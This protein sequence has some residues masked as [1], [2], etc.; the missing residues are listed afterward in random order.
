MFL[1]FCTDF[2]KEETDR[3]WLGILDHFIAIN[4]LT[5]ENIKNDKILNESGPEL[6]KNMI[7]VLQSNDVLST[8]VWTSTWEKIDNL[9]PELKKELGNQ[10]DTERAN[11]DEKED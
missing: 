6:L 3:V 4:N 11:I 9:Y 2:K 5:Q 1:N 10:V 8:D 7:L